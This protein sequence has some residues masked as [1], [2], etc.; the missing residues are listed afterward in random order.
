[1]SGGKLW[2]PK[3]SWVTT[4][5][6]SRVC[7]DTR[8]QREGTIKLQVSNLNVSILQGITWNDYGSDSDIV[9]VMMMVITV[10]T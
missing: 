6:G 10:M 3:G 7:N 5:E 9:A 8:I 1:M 4:L 2:E